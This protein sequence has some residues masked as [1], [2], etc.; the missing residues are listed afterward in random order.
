MT[1]A[2]P[3]FIEGRIIGACNRVFA[4]RKATANAAVTFAQVN[5]TVQTGM[6]TELK[7]SSDLKLE[8]LILQVVHGFY[9]GLLREVLEQD[10]PVPAGFEAQ[11]LLCPADLEHTLGE[12]RRWLRL[13]DLAITPAMVRQA[14]TERVD[15]ELAAA[16]LRYYVRQRSHTDFT[17]DKT[18]FVASFL[19]RYPRIEGLWDRRGYSPEGPEPAAPPFESALLEILGDSPLPEL[20]SDAA[21]NLRE[22]NSMRAQ[23]ESFRH[24]SALIDSGIIQKSR[25][26]KHAL[27]AALYHPHTLAVIAPYNTFLGNRFTELFRAA[28]AHIRSFAEQVQSRSGSVQGII[29][30]DVTLNHLREVREEE[31][32][33]TEYLRAQ[34]KLRHIIKLEKAVDSRLQ[35]GVL[36]ARSAA[37]PAAG[38]L[39]AGIIRSRADQLLAPKPVN[40]EEESRLRSIQDAICSCVRESDPHSRHLAPLAFANIVLSPA[41]ADACCAGY[42]RETSFRGDNARALVRL[43]A[44][45]ARM[46]AEMENLESRQNSMY[47]W[48][49]HAER[50]HHLLAAGEQARM[51][52][53]R[54]IQLATQRGLL[55]KVKTL[56]ASMQKLEEKCEAVTGL[57]TFFEQRG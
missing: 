9:L 3:G 57:L 23:V 26:I 2:E 39:Q 43:V 52:T 28:T 50:L 32:L 34:E 14:L 45:S 30:G 7:L 27:G 11:S 22:F 40:S 44:V 24:F 46:T 1:A 37:L 20:S 51:D 29:A 41:E 36:P 55:E 8:L 10:V 47:L 17:R 4:A 53:K 5:A 19:Y 42:L 15:R 12:I 25:H 49:P 35:A 13:L 18:D 56:N 48:R 6:A 21:R 38:Q 33:A 31:I 16:L 54:V